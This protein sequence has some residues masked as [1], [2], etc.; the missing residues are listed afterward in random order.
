MPCFS[1]RVAAHGPVR[2]GTSEVKGMLGDCE[3]RVRSR[4]HTRGAHRGLH[5]SLELSAR[6]N[7]ANDS[8][9]SSAS[10]RS[11]SLDYYYY[12]T[13]SLPNLV[14]SLRNDSALTISVLPYTTL[15]LLTLPAAPWPLVRFAQ[16]CKFPYSSMLPPPT[17]KTMASLKPCLRWP[18]EASIPLLWPPPCLASFADGGIVPRAFALRGSKYRKLSVFCSADVEAF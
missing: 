10:S 17:V 11:E 3:S 15:F 18:K 14:S 4:Q 7:G 12:H 1:H 9:T 6:R 16:S 5:G 8:L 2:S 13:L